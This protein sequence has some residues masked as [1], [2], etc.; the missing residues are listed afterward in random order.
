MI[1]EEYT[2]FWNGPFS[3]W[4]ASPFMDLNGLMY[5]CCEQAM[6]AHKAM[7]F[8]DEESFKKIMATTSPREQKAL[9]RKVKNFNPKVWD[10][11]SSLIVYDMNLLK[12]SQNK[13]HQEALLKTGDT[14]L[15]EASPYDKIW[16][17]SM[18]EDD[19]RINDMSQWKGQN[20]LGFILTRVREVL[21]D[22]MAHQDIK[23]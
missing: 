9:G 13:K 16:G 4:D 5:N 1:G 19:S 15:V 14:I 6:M 10:V 7:T 11:M 3:Q 2:F 12:F 20:R 17:V 18:S 8:K 22:E 23:A 21:K